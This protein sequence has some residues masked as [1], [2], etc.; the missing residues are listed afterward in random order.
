VHEAMRQL[1]AVARLESRQQVELSAVIRPVVGAAERHD[2]V[3]L[4]ATAE[5]AR[6]QVGRVHRALAA[7]DASLATY[8]GALRVGRRRDLGA[9]QR[10]PP[11]K[12]A[13]AAQRGATLAACAG[14]GATYA[15]RR[16]L[17]TSIM[18]PAAS[19][20]VPRCWPWSTTAGARST[21]R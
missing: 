19:G 1:G 9:P 21:S 13:S 5:G 14:A 10:C 18:E 15:A 2:T 17:C 12:A 11:L 3:G 4:V 20:K 7:H 16:D 6:D 8:L